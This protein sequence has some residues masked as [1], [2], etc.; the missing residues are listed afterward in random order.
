V[1]VS[2]FTTG[3]SDLLSLY[4]KLLNII[5]ATLSNH[6]TGRDSSPLNVN[7]TFSNFILLTLR[8]SPP[9]QGRGRASNRG[10][11]IWVLHAPKLL[12]PIYSIEILRRAM[13]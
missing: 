1:P 3:F 9:Q 4:L 7:S 13:F 6:N 5:S 2:I 8:I 11:S 10:R 12:F